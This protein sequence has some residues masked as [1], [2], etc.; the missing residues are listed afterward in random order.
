[1]AELVD[2]LDSKS[3]SL[4]RVRVRFPS[5]PPFYMKVAIFTDVFLEVPG[6]IPSSIVAQREY[7]A[8]NGISSIVFCPATPRS[9]VPEGVFAVPS[10]KF[11]RPGGAPFS[12]RISKV[13]KAILKAYP[14]FDFDLVHVHY[15]AACSLA[16]MQLAREFKKPLIQTMHGRED[17]AAET[18]IPHP[19]KTVGGA[20]LCRLHKFGVPHP[21]K[22]KRDDYLAPTVCQA[23]MWT[24][25]VNHANFADAVITPSKHFKDKL[26]HYGVSQPFYVISNAISDEVL[27][28]NFK[29]AGM[30]YDKPK[31]REYNGDEPLKLFWNSRVSKEKRIMPFLKALTLTKASFEMEV[32]GDG[33]DLS[34]AKKYAASHQLKV[35]FYGRIDHKKMLERMYEAD[36]AVV[37][38]YGFDNQPMTI[39]EA[40]S[41]GLPTLVCDPDLME[42]TGEGGLLTSDSSSEAMAKALDELYLHPGRLKELSQKCLDDRTRV[43]QSVQINK[44]IELYKF[45]VK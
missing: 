21:L 38:S 32:Y 5:R 35:K 44:L 7:L 45:L 22:V 20:L 8:K 34:K 37:A 10:F 13:K 17:V 19:L 24:L 12:K 42:V 28:T 23:K 16:G 2:A 27:K 1:M 15:E 6:G 43:L 29:E 30:N 40:V 31:T 14:E 3:G 41:M 26:Q 25:M 9:K 11:L 33:N 36:L 18:N 39:L 4:R